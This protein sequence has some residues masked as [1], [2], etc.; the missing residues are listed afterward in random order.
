[1]KS[2]ERYSTFLSCHPEL[3]AYNIWLSGHFC[4][5][6]SVPDNLHNQCVSSGN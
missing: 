3:W 2:V 4:C 1:M 5:W 6:N